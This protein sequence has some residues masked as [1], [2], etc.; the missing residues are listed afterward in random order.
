P[1]GSARESRAGDA[2]WLIDLVA[3]VS[4]RPRAQITLDTRLS[5]LGRL[6]DEGN[7]YLV[8]RSKEIIV[9][10]NGK[11]VYPDE[12][13]EL[14]S[15]SPF[16]KELSVVGLQ[17]GL[18]EKVACLV[19]ADYDH[20]IALSRDEVR[21]RVE[22]HFRDVSSTLPFYKRVKVLHF[23]DGELP[24]TAT[25][26]VKRREVATALEALEQSARTVPRGSARESRAGDAAWLIDLVAIVSGRPRA[27]I[28]LDTR[29]SDLGGGA[30]TGR[31]DI[32]PDA[33]PHRRE[34]RPRRVAAPLLRKVPQHF[35]RGARAH[36]RPH[37]LH[38]RRQPHLAP[39]HG[40]GEDRARRAGARHGGARRG[41]L[42]FR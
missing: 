6:D 11:N 37:E 32:H 27:Q 36:P 33:H 29:L 12:I 24:R 21:R 22:E 2:A 30:Q 19:V 40:A 35:L 42:L 39:R 23:W 26:K 9:D 18:G 1:R 20:D 10:T 41:R 7:L 14:Y 34:S 17:D 28:T 4:G 38:R 5:D 3:I 16:I 15:D 31:R 8:G 13:E 25:R